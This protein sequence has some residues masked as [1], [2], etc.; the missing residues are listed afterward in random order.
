M[1]TL[2]QA[3]QSRADKLEQGLST[4]GP[5]ILAAMEDTWEGQSKKAAAQGIVDYVEK[6]GNLVSGTKIVAGK[7]E[8][9][10]SAVEV[11]KA[12]VQPSPD[13]SGWGSKV[14]SWTPGPTWKMNEDRTNAAE[15]ATYTILEKVYQP[16]IREG[17]TGQ[18]RIP[19]AYNPV[20]DPGTVPPVV[21]PPGSW[22]PDERG[23]G[24]WDPPATPGGDEEEE[25]PGTTGEDT[26][27]TTTAGVDP[28]TNPSTVNNNTTSGIGTTPASTTAA[29]TG[30]GSLAGT[31][32]AP[33]GLG[34]G[35][36]GSGSGGGSD[37]GG[38]GS[39]SRAGG[40]VSGVPG[41]A[42]PGGPGRS[43]PG[44]G[45]PGIGAATTGAGAAPRGGARPM[46]MGPMMPPGARGGK[47]DEENEKG[48][49]A[50]AEA[51]VNQRNGEELTGLDP[52][53]RP[54]TVPPVLGE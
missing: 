15:L 29:S 12:N 44:T 9:V 33:G 48:K 36:L 3:W 14:A 8:L 46:A 32:Y 5:K 42:A 31:G 52:E 7:V 28:S 25:G 10:K 2:H 1:T 19:L 41:G 22:P 39:G 18:P 4:F 45:G 51:L 17:D 40:S 43:L 50:I 38:T 16:G 35:T 49:S 37:A 13:T 20:H 26:D 23:G 6:A 53:H 34:T 47:G 21:P 54:K 30:T 24:Q 11:T 27:D